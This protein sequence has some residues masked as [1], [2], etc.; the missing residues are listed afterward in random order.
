MHDLAG[1]IRHCACSQGAL[2]GID[3]LAALPGL[4]PGETSHWVLTGDSDGSR[5][6]VGAA[7]VSHG[8]QT[9]SPA[10]RVAADPLPLLGQPGITAVIPTTPVAVQH[11]RLVR[12]VLTGGLAVELLLVDAHGDI[13][14]RRTMPVDDSLP[15]DPAILAGFPD[16]LS[17][18]IDATARPSDT[19]ASCHPTAFAAWKRTRHAIAL[20]SLPPADRTDACIGCH[21]TMV[22]ARTLAPAVGCQACHGG[23]DAHAVSGGTARTTGA[24]DCRTC[25]DA[26]H[27]P[28]FQ[29]ETAWGRMEHGRDQRSTP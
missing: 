4:V 2:G 8:W 10:I 11:R 26:Q 16:T 6:G 15:A 19:C 14:E 27:H 7:L 28:G 18:T 9:G 5:P 24:G 17:S 12:P 13:Q 23:A 3:R 25:H 22:A 1:T 20:D 29:R 21:T